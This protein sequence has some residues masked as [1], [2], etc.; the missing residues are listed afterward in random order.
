MVLLPLPPDDLVAA[1]AEGDGVVSTS[2]AGLV[3]AIALDDRG[4][5][6]QSRGKL[7]VVVAAV[8]VDIDGGESSGRKTC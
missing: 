3:I 1:G 5:Q 4:R 8:A 2:R 6:R 7:E